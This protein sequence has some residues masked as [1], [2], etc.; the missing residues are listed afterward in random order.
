MH[1]SVI[2]NRATSHFLFKL[3]TIDTGI[4][5]MISPLA[6]AMELDNSYRVT[7]G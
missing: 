1:S 3:W 7:P 6:L 5:D 4:I 2:R